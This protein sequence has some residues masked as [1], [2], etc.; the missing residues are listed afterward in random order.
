MKQPIFPGNTPID[1]KRIS[2]IEKVVTRLARRAVKKIAAMITPY[3]ISHASFG[4]DVKGVILCYMFPCKGVITKGFI[5]IGKKLNSGATVSMSLSSGQTN[6]SVSESLN[7]DSVLIEPNVSVDPGT[8]L[9][10]SVTPNDDAEKMTEVWISFLWTPS[11]K[12]VEIKSYL[13]DELDNMEVS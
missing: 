5:D 2:F 11:I 10:V 8:K 13:I 12:D 3:P 6:R 1:E 4:D 7:E 9:I